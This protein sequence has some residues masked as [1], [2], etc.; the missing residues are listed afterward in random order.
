MDSFQFF[1]WEVRVFPFSHFLHI[2]IEKGT[3]NPVKNGGKHKK[4]EKRG[5]KRAG[6]R[7]L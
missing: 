5:E 1:S 2:R 3:K 4:A 7:E 6:K